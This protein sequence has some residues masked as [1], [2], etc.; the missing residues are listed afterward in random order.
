MDIQLRL[1]QGSN[2]DLYGATNGY[3]GT[4]FRVGLNGAFATLCNFSGEN[5]LGPWDLIRANDG[6]F[7]GVTERG[8]AQNNGT[9]FKTTPSGGPDN[10]VQFFWF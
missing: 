6:N 7:Y 3:P 4:V 8:G 2:G 10:V 9:V 5:G 1:V